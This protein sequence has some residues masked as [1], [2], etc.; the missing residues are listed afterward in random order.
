MA[1]AKNYAAKLAVRFAYATNGQAI[2]G[3]DMATGEEGERGR[4]SRRRTSCGR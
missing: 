3:I 2:Y 4:L 1:Q